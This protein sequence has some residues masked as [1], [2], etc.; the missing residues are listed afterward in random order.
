MSGSSRRR[1]DRGAQAVVGAVRRH[2]HVDDG[3]VGAVRATALRSSVVGV[4]RLGHDVDA[5]LL[6]QAGE[7]LAQE[8]LVLR[9]QD[10]RRRH[11]PGW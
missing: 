10:A 4:A 6:E 3:D 7:A 9:D 11:R 1:R 5:L 8:D 2:L